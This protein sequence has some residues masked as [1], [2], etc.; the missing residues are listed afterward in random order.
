MYYVKKTTDIETAVTTYYACAHS[1]LNYG[2]ITWGN[3]AEA[4]T[5][6]ITK[7]IDSFSIII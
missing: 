5:V 4:Y 7:D 1:W 6:H 3:G 2:I